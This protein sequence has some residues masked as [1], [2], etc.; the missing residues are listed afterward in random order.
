MAPEF[1]E[2]L[3]TSGKVEPQK[4]PQHPESYL[5][6]VFKCGQRREHLI[7]IHRSKWP[8]KQIA[9]LNDRPYVSGTCERCGGTCLVYDPPPS[10]MTVV[11]YGDP[12]EAQGQVIDEAGP[13]VAEEELPQ[14]GEVIDE[15]KPHR[16]GRR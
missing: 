9:S 7:R 5:S 14:A 3:T 12:S 2:D 8:P 6:G 13:V 1:I 10:D 11:L 15:P 4:R 16:R